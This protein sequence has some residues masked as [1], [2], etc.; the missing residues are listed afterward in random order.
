[1]LKGLSNEFKVG[2]MTVI[3]LFILFMGYNF[4]M[5]KDNIFNRG[6]EFAV[7]YK[8]TQGLSVGAKVL[9]NGYKIGSL[10]SLSMDD[11]QQIVAL[12]EIT[13]SMSIPKNSSLKIQSELLGGVSLRLVMGNSLVMAMPG[14][15]LNAS[16]SKDIFDLVN[17]QIVGVASSTD[18]LFNTLN[19]LLKK[20]ELNSALIELP[21]IM[22]TLSATL[23]DIKLQI[24]TMG[25]S[26]NTSADN[27]AKFSSNLPEYD[28]NIREGFRHINALGTQIDTMR[29]DK[30]ANNLTKSLSQITEILDN[31]EEGKGSLGKLLNDDQLYNSL[32]K[33][34]KEVQNLILDLKRYPEKYIPVPLSVKQRSRAKKKS[35]ADSAIFN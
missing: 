7:I 2:L 1:M 15:T 6:R 29:V 32:I 8:N 30:L 18:S 33:S 23:E 17:K 26:L 24:E 31:L 12:V 27:M 13:S 10:R 35:N 11:N 28:H 21:K 20:D 14:D 9:V 3:S 19:V 4:M 25:P 5:G 34:N 22:R 16:Y